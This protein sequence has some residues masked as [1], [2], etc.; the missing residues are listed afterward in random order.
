MH[1]S[2][3]TP[4]WQTCWPVQAWVIVA[5][6]P[7]SSHDHTLPSLQISSPGVHATHPSESTHAIGQSIVVVH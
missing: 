1:A 5:G 4:S 7:V 2:V 6:S 3:H